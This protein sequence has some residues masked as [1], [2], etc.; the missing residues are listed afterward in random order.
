MMNIM[1][2]NGYKAVIHYDPEIDMFRGEFMG[3]NGDAD[4]YAGD[5]KSLRKEGEIS[6]KVFLDMC[7]EDEVEPLK[8]FSGKFNLRIPPKL[9]AEIVTAAT[10]EGKSLNKWIINTLAH[11]THT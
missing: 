4:F 8:E 3:L 9:H 5:I 1:E 6:L 2:I 7:A 10:S 11:A